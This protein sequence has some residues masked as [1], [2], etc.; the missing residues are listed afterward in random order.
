LIR[1]HLRSIPSSFI[2]EKSFNSRLQSRREKI[3]IGKKSSMTGK[4]PGETKAEYTTPLVNKGMAGSQKRKLIRE[5]GKG[6]PIDEL[7]LAMKS[8][9]GGLMCSQEK[10]NWGDI[11]EVKGDT[12]VG[13]TRRQITCDVVTSSF[14]RRGKRCGKVELRMFRSRAQNEGLPT[15]S[16]GQGGIAL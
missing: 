4:R 13:E 11:L 1:Y 14:R 3:N 5:K 12:T 15:R 2:F 9:R 10:S 7:T 8:L 6:P 16:L